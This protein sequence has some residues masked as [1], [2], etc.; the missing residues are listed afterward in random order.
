MSDSRCL[1]ILSRLPGS[2]PQLARTPRPVFINL[3]DRARALRA[4]AAPLTSSQDS[5]QKVGPLT[6]W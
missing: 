6:Q 5:L 2:E 3:A 1:E 4:T